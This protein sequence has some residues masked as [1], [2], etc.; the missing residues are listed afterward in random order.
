MIHIACFIVCMHFNEKTIYIYQDFLYTKLEIGMVKVE[1]K[2]CG[3]EMY[4]GCLR[5]AIHGTVAFFS[6][7]QRA[8]Y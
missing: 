1:A 5:A 3:Q 2:G 7:W 6:T 8:R 4:K